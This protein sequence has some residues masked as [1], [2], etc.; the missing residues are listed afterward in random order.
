VTGTTSDPI[1]FQSSVTKQ[2]CW[3][4]SPNTNSIC[5]PYNAQI[6]TGLPSDASIRGDFCLSYGDGAGEMTQNSTKDLSRFFG[7]SV[8]NPFFEKIDPNTKSGCAIT[9][10]S[11][12]W[13][14]VLRGTQANQHCVPNNCGI[15]HT[16][17]APDTSDRPWQDGRS[18]YIGVTSGV[19]ADNAPASVWHAFVCAGLQD[20]STNQG[21][22][23]CEETWRSDSGVFA[24]CATN[25]VK[26]GY[27]VCRTSSGQVAALLVG[28]ATTG[29]GF[30][31]YVGPD[32]ST[33]GNSDYNIVWSRPQPTAQLAT[34]TGSNFVSNNG[35]GA[36]R[37][38]F[39]IS[40][41]QLSRCIAMFNIA[42]KLDQAK[43]LDLSRTPMSTDLDNWDIGNV[44]VGAEGQSV[45]SS[46]SAWLGMTTQ[47][48][49]ITSS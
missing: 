41:A 12:R 35:F 31:E 2:S 19:V 34:S 45:G 25:T 20:V 5:T 43:N 40:P 46:T 7:F 22:L 17:N 9:G 18:L 28:G 47:S 6:Q 32:L 26:S 29:V 37:F 38:T 13:G 23:F 30:R 8:T 27:G 21:F 11:S 4:T 48:L 15:Q 1:Y 10:T 24:T 44:G 49:S 16:V 36:R 39:Q 14:M 33:T 3:E 42:L